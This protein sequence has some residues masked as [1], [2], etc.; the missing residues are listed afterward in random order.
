VGEIK[1]PEVRQFLEEQLTA[2]WA[3][4]RATVGGPF[5]ADVAAEILADWPE[6]GSE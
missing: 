3:R 2:P 6:E 4:H 5:L 1:E